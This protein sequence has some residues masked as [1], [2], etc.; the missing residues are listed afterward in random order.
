MVP[1]M[2]VL[3]CAL[4]LLP[5]CGFAQVQA[6]GY[7]FE[8]LN[9]NGIK[10]IGEPGIADVKVSNQHE[11]TKTDKSGFW[12]MKG[13]DDTIFFVVK[14]RNWMTPLNEFN[15]PQFHYIHKPNGSPPSL[16]TPGVEPTGPLPEFINFPLHRREETTWFR[17][18]F[19][20]DTQPRNATEVDYLKRDIIEPL[21]EEAKKE[22]YSFGVTLG[23]L[24]F[25]DLGVFDPYIRAIALLGMPWY[26]V[27]GNH[28]INKDIPDDKLSDETFERLFGPNYY[29]FDHGPTHFVV[30]DNVFWYQNPQTNRGSYKGRFGEEQLAWLKKDLALVPPDQLVVMMM[31]IPFQ[32]TEDKEEMFKVIGDR[33]YCLS[34]SAH[35]H[36][37]EHKFLESEHLKKP[38]HHVINV[39]TCGS[40]WQGRPDDR[41]VPIT[42]MRD[43]A[44]NGFSV[45]TFD[46][47]QYSIEFRAAGSPASHQMNIY[48][49]ELLKRYE[50]EGTEIVVNVFGG[51]EKSVVE[52]KFGND[53]EWIKMDKVMR[54]DPQYAKIADR[55]KD[56]KAPYR[57]LPAPIESPHLWAAKLPRP[58]S[59]GTIPVHI[60][61]TDMFGQVYYATRGIRI[62]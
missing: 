15:L 60:R 45:F 32:D 12:T 11:F 37:Q 29:S 62:E 61:T 59:R 23:D 54:A 43:G 48:A 46:G 2:R 1:A 19:F 24:V 3:L 50:A 20:G 18:L 14:P 47:N 38:H 16:K 35:T 6:K 39:T 52:M 53:G 27:L 21:I 31:H 58:S 9:R 44:P 13:T 17:A 7:V 4:S 30:L 42:T 28:D 56:L 33:P 10:E 40:W 34:V 36:Y 49:P 55:D 41:G 51:N 22:K 5:V 8:D 25:D 26:N 57:P